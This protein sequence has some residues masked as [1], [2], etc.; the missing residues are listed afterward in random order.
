ML[1]T[2]LAIVV[3]FLLGNSPA[4][5]FYMPTFRNT[6][7]I[8]SSQADRCRIY[9]Y[10]PMKIEQT[11]CS[12]TSAYK[13]QTPGNYPEESTQHSEHGESLK[14]RIVQPL[15]QTFAVFR[16]L[17]SF[18]WVFPRR[19]NFMCRRFGTLC[20]IF[21]GGV[22]RKNLLTPPMNMEQCAPK[23]RHIKF[24]RR[25]ITQTKEYSK[26]SSHISQVTA[27]FFG[28]ASAAVI[29]DAR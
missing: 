27:G 25:G 6:L 21:I 3:C 8:P 10:P 5:E 15:F 9:R 29:V 28:T 11:E 23:R 19:L 12:E 13:I 16:M 24:R 18:L 2:S 17:C 7:S 22:S 1:L 26:Q 14:S 20:S 4:Y